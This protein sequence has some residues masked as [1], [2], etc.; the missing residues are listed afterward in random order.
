M[1]G[2]CGAI[3]IKGAGVGVGV[4][5]GLQGG[6]GLQGKKPRARKHSP[7]GNLPQVGSPAIPYG[8]VIIIKH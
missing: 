2:Y 1:P 7:G 5:P 6:H 3:A 4:L 8:T